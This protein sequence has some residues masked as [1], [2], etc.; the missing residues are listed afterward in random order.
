MKPPQ[1][2][3]VLADCN[4]ALDLD[5]SYVKALNRRGAALEGMNRYQE[6]VRGMYKP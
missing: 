3:M 1:H 5:P 2:D 6:A 4:A